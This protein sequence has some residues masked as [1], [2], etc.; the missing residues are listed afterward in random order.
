MNA[1]LEAAGRDDINS[2]TQQLRQ[3]PTQPRQGHH[4]DTLVEV[5]EQVDIAAIGVFATGNAAEDTHVVRTSTSGKLD[6]AAPVLPQSP[7]EPGVRKPELS[8]LCG[9]K[10]NDKIMTGCLDQLGECP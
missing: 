8:A 4:T 1:R 5:D 3:F 2:D 6:D 10:L 7:T 9:N